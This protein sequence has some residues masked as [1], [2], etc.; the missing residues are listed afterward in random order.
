VCI[1]EAIE[2]AFD[3]LEHVDQSSGVTR[4]SMYDLKKCTYN[5]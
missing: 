1:Y 5:Q 2:K 3:R 4:I